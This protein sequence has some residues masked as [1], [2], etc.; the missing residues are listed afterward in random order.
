[1]CGCQINAS[2]EA[3]AVPQQKDLPTVA[4][5]ENSLVSSVVMMSMQSEEDPLPH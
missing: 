5:Q 4:V 3:R 2:A 1:M